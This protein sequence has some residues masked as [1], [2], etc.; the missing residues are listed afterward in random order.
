M[1]PGHSSIVFVGLKMTLADVYKVPAFVSLAVI[2]VL[3]AVAVGAS[4]LRPAPVP[5]AEADEPPE[6]VASP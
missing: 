4:L 3:L 5:E 2:V 1:N 6:A